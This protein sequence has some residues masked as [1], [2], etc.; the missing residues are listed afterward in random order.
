MSYTNWSLRSVT[1]PAIKL[2]GFSNS[3]S[4]MS[5]LHGVRMNYLALARIL[6][7]MNPLN[8]H[9]NWTIRQQLTLLTDT[10]DIRSTNHIS[11]GNHTAFTAIYPSVFVP[12]AAGWAGLRTVVFV[13]LDSTAQLIVQQPRYLAV[14]SLRYLLSLGS[15][16][17]LSSSIK[18]LPDIGFGIGKRIG[19]FASCFMQQVINSS[20]R[21]IQNAIFPTLQP[22]PSTRAFRL[23]GL[24]LLDF[25]QSLIPPLNCRLN[26]STA[27]QN[28]FVAI[29]CRNQRVH[30][31]INP[32]RCTDWF[33]LVW[34]FAD[35]FDQTIVQ[36]GFHQS[37]WQF[38]VRQLDFQ[39][40]C[41]ATRQN[42]LPI[43]NPCPLIS[44]NHALVSRLSPGVASIR[45]SSAKLTGTLHRFAE[46][47][48]DLLN[49][50]RMQIRIQTLGFFLQL[51][52]RCPFLI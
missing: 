42:Q 38:D 35:E 33:N 20:P 52:F 2:R 16:S 7:R 44:E 22:F 46:V 31:Q 40:P 1:L 27:D 5:N 29:G 3:R 19:N 51:G 21:F 23:G 6:C 10:Q 36:S 25:C 37:S 17:C 18:G 43:P 26:R 41:F 28:S 15:T 39:L 24:R 32:N 9:R 12:L 4:R 13:G 34:Y 47:S 45:V 14:A 11:G 48:N 30:T 8:Q 50:L 49:R